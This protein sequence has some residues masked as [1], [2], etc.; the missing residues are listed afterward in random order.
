MDYFEK[1]EEKPSEDL[2]WNIPDRKLGVVNVIGG[3]TQNFRAEVKVS[4]FL[5]EKYPIETINTIL[6]DSLK[7]KLPPLPNFVFLK[8]TDVGSFAN[9]EELEKKFN[10]A[11][12]NLLIGDL[13]KNSIT[14]RA[15]A[16]ACISSEKPLLI[17][18]DTVDLIAENSPEKVILNENLIIFG[19][20]AQLQKLFRTIYY[21]KM[22][23]LS[24]S[25]IQV[26]DTLH[27]FTLSYPISIITLHNGQILIAKNGNV[28]AVALEITGYSPV[29]FWQGEL[30]SK[31]MVLNLFN[32]DNFMKASIFALFS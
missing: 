25:L 5:S 3:N 26:A 28:R 17:T 7:E 31:I 2:G 23:L 8:S 9:E 6:P 11:D 29:G 15:V 24:Q 4:E 12:F 20:M 22:L 32:P 13:S 19:S 27:K 1:I 14:G 10:A 16:G 30:A 18:R 21:P